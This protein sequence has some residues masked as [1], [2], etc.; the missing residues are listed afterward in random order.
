VKV[1]TISCK[2]SNIIFVTCNKMIKTQLYEY[3][4]IFFMNVKK[5]M[6]RFQLNMYIIQE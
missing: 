4:S 3:D 5:L 1:G 2:Q 6:M